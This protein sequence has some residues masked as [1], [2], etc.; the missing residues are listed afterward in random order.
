MVILRAVRRGWSVPA[1]LVAGV[2]I[3]ALVCGGRPTALLAVGAD[4]RGDSVLLTGAVSTEVNQS[5]KVQITQ[6]GV[7]YLNYDK[8]LLLAAVPL[9]R[10]TTGD[11]QILS[12][13]AV[14]DLVKDFG[15]APNAPCKFLATTGTLGSLSEGWAPIYV[16]EAVSG[17]LGI[18][19]VQPQVTPGSNR[20]L[21]SLLQIQVDARFAQRGRP[22]Q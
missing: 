3:G 15:V 16:L 7:Y 17:R 10:Q 20:P 18:Y 4:R 8:G 13:W 11:T 1:A 5:S 12:D 19:R 6:D 9:T 21:F 14:R 22:A 2:V